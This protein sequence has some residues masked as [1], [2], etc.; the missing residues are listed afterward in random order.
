MS[1]VTRINPGNDD[2]STITTG[3]KDQDNIG[4]KFP[5]LPCLPA[6]APSTWSAKI[7]KS[8]G[9]T[10]SNATSI[11]IPLVFTCSDNGIAP[12]TT[13]EE[14]HKPIH[15]VGAVTK[16]IFSS[17]ASLFQHWSRKIVAAAQAASGWN[18]FL[19]TV[20]GLVDLRIKGDA[21]T[22]RLQLLTRHCHCDLLFTSRIG[23]W[24]YDAAIPLNVLAAWV[25][26]QLF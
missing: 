14:C 12:P 3:N 6:S 16:T 24:T 5:T 21:V 1:C 18:I 9:K 17:S 4:D 20:A 25:F 22:V 7:H 8:V 10:T 23:V 15:E 13:S 26:S 19:T 11:S 2:C